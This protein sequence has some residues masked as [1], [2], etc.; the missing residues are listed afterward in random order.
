MCVLRASG[1]Q[2]DVDA[3]LEVSALVPVSVHRCGEP[4]GPSARPDGSVHAT[5]GMNISVSDVV[6]SD[7]LPASLVAAAGKLGL[8][9]EIS[10]Y[11]TDQDE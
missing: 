6:Q 8:A 4:R 7:R 10:I 3:F 11:P 1:T 9:L 5:S 2:F